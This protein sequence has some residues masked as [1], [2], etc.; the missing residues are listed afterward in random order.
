MAKN[1]ILKEV[2]M[3]GKTVMI[4]IGFAVIMV[5]T[6]L[7]ISFIANSNKFTPEMKDQILNIVKVLVW[8]WVVIFVVIMVCFKDRLF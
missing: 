7:S 2:T 3:K 8:L 1:I 6:I 5:L 4:L